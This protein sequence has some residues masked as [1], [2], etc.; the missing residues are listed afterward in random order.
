[1]KYIRLSV[2]LLVLILP[3]CFSPVS[4]ETLSE[5][6]KNNDSLYL[7]LSEKNEE[8]FY[9]RDSIRIARLRDSTDRSDK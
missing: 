6:K 9:L 2:I 8:V 1:M 7:Q 4:E 5:M 3:A